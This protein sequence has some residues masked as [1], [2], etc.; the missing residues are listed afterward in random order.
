MGAIW[1]YTIVEGENIQQAYEK[2]RREARIEFG[3][4]PYNGTITTSDGYEEVTPP[5]GFSYDELLELI[6][7]EKE[8]SIKYP[9]VGKEKWGSCGAMK[10]KDEK[11]EMHGS[12][13]EKPSI[14]DGKYDIETKKTF[15]FWGVFAS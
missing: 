5:N 13:L 14:I 12:T 4:N 7:N 8:L 3:N 10:I 11:L 15:A 1:D 6:S 9:N 2:A